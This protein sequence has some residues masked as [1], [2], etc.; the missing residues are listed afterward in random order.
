[1]GCGSSA[2]NTIPPSAEVVK[3]NVP[4]TTKT[5]PSVEETPK[6]GDPDAWLTDWQTPSESDREGA[7]TKIQAIQRG[8]LARADCVEYQAR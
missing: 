1:M 8:R 3:E 7:A 2:A 4:F 6:D 5:A